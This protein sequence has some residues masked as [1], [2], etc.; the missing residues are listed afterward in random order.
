MTGDATERH[1]P[2]EERTLLRRPAPAVTVAD[3]VLH[4]LDLEA[5][6]G[7]AGRRIVLGAAPLSIGRSPQNGLSLPSGDVSRTHCVVALDGGVAVATDL[8]S[9]NG[10]LVDGIR[11]EGPARLAHGARIGLGPFVLVYRTGRASDLAREEEARRE[12]ERAR[13]YIAALLPAPVAQGPVRADWRFVPSAEVGG[14]GFGY[15]WLDA[16]RFAVWLLDVSGHGAGSALL[17]ASVM[18]LLREHSQPGMDFA[19]PGALLSQLNARFQAERQGGLFFT[20]WY[21]VADVAERRLAFACAGQHPAF[22]LAPGAAPAPLAV[23]NPGVGL[24]PDFAFRTAEAALPAG[25]RLVLFSDGAFE[26]RGAD[27]AQRGIQDFI[28]A[29]AAQAEPGLPEAE[30]LLR[31]ARAGARPGPPEDDIAILCLDFA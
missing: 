2:E 30:R 13:R 25:S 17:A 14:D 4:V 23:R 10:T 20:I 21:G 7:V 22:L 9:T 1:G 16:R 29:I 3:P 6:E 15:G 26:T 31:A 24:A 12:M 5:A 11:A 27:G 8:G 18:N 19:S 28:P